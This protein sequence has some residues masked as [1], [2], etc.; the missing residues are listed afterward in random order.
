MKEIPIV[1]A[2]RRPGHYSHNSR[3]FKT[4]TGVFEEV[5]KQP[6]I[7]FDLL[8]MTDAPF[9]YQISNLILQY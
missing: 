5:L 8:C 1:V 9:S 7:G 6:M 3:E 2:S 4:G